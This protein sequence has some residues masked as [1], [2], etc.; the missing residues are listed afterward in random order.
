MSKKCTLTTIAEITGVLGV[1]VAVIFG[2]N[3]WKSSSNTEQNE[4]GSELFVDGSSDEIV[5]SFIDSYYDM[6]MRRDYSELD[7]YFNFPVERFYDLTNASSSEIVEQLRNYYS[8]WKFQ[9]INIDKKTLK[10]I[11]TRDGH[12][13]VQFMLDYQ[14]KENEVDRY[15]KFRLQISMYFDANGKLNSIYEMK[16]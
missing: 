12:K 3:Q 7:N 1:I 8:K 14:T 2:I 11:E 5:D 4:L 16:K 15:K 6:L 13:K 10:V 9:R